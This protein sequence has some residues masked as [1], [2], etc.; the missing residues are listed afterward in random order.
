MGRSFDIEC[1]FINF[2]SFDGEDSKKFQEEF[3]FPGSLPLP[4]PGQLA[5]GTFKPKLRFPGQGLSCQSLRWNAG[6]ISSRCS[7]KLE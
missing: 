2:S 5:S 1:P 7:A 3:I 6:G 4:Q